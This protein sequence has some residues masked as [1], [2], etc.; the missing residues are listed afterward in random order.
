M[1]IYKRKLRKH[2]LLDERPIDPAFAK[3]ETF[4]ELTLEEEI[5]T[6]KVAKGMTNQVIIK[7]NSYTV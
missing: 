2:E 6:L 4:P 3:S 5:Q 1:A 7:G